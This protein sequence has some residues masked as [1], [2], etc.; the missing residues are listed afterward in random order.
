M[1]RKLLAAGGLFLM[2]GIV[3]CGG[4]AGTARTTVATGPE[5]GSTVTT[6]TAD[7]TTTPN[8]SVL[9]PI[10]VP[11]LPDVIPGYAE[12]DPATGL[13]VTG[14]AQVIDVA[15]YRLKV[16]GKVDRELSLSYDDLRRLPKVTATP[17]L[18]CPGVF[19][20]TATWSGVPL[21]TILDMAGVQPDA[22]EIR[23]NA[24][25]GHWSVLAL[26]KA[27]KPENFLA[28]ELADQPLP[29]LHG[30]PLRAVLPDEYGSLWV[31]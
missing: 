31:K 8:S 26:D 7:A 3:G 14:T 17:R 27:F 20:D 18:V 30:F 24:A 28:Y 2:L 6:I 11:T 21:K 15:S 4:A 22:T 12:L 29:V 25:D 5:T 16:D 13:H 19:E 1:F 10:V 23:M 9:E